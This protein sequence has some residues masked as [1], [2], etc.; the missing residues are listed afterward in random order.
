MT[1]AFSAPDE[2]LKKLQVGIPSALGKAQESAVRAVGAA[3]AGPKWLLRLHPE[4][5]EGLSRG[6]FTTRKSQEHR[7]INGRGS[8]ALA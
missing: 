3:Q 6:S 8:E 2:V 5:C 1:W 7:L 4:S